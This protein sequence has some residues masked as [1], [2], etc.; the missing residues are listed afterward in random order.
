MKRQFE[1]TRG[2]AK[3]AIAAY[4]RQYSLK[5]FKLADGRDAADIRRKL[6]ALKRPTRK[7]VE[8]IIGDNGW[9]DVWCSS[10]SEYKSPVV[11]FGESGNDV[12]V[13]CLKAA[14]RELAQ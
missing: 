5:P 6:E 14:L 10:C 1:I 7:A 2:G 11:S 4:C 3:H 12:C 9:T 8:K 13:D